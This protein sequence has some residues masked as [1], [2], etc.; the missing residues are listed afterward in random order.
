MIGLLQVKDVE[1]SIQE[2]VM[3][4]VEE[5]LTS[6]AAAASGLQNAN[7]SAAVQ[8]A[9]ES[10]CNVLSAIADP[11][12]NAQSSL[13]QSL[14]AIAAKRRLKGDKIAK[15]LQNIIASDD[16]GMSHLSIIYAF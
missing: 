3:D 10:L 13:S 7:P 16:R 6:K 2:A 15:G 14:T 12:L 1:A 8:D 5:L 11:A 9:A 4:Q